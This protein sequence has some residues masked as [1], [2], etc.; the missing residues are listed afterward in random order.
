MFISRIQV[1]QAFPRPST[2]A[3]RQNSGSAPGCS[4]PKKPVENMTAA[5]HIQ[6]PMASPNRDAKAGI[7]RLTAPVER[8]DG[9]VQHR[10]AE[11]LVIEGWRSE[12][13]Q[14]PIETKH[15][16]AISGAK[17]DLAK[18]SSRR[19]RRVCDQKMQPEEYCRRNIGVN[20]VV[21]AGVM[22]K[23]QVHRVQGSGR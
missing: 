14:K 3:L 16:S 20:E 7:Q 2:H 10:Y 21:E 4:L 23:N 17:H 11:Q 15:C 22:G 19:S 6:T 5:R 18:V 8:P 12:P 13:T 1:W 9:Q